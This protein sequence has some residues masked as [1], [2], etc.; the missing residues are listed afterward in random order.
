VVEGGELLGVVSLKDL[1]DFLS[2]KL[3]LEANSR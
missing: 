3:D 1:M 2:L